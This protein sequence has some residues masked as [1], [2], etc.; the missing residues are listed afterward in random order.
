[1][2]S[3]IGN[4]AVFGLATF[5]FSLAVLGYQHVADEKVAGATVFA[6]LV[7]AI[8]ETIAGI[9]SVIRGDTYVG[10]V[11]TTFG[12]WLFG[13]YMFVTSDPTRHYVSGKSAGVYVLT[14]V[15]PVLYLAAPAVRARAV[16]LTSAFAAV[17]AVLLLLGYGAYYAKT[18]LVKA[19]GWAALLSALLVFVMSLRDLLAAERDTASIADSTEN[20]AASPAR[21][22]SS[23]GVLA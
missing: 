8:G 16:L 4:P 12:L 1:M 6:L 9:I 22:Q 7:G 10:S 17:L 14:L 18:D 5:G 3:K 13:Y 2:T 11:L 21:A 19:G 23:P 20:T 15:I